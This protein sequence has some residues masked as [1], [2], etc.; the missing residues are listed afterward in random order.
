MSP[1]LGPEPLHSLREFSPST[2]K[3][4]V[5]DGLMFLRDIGVLTLRNTEVK[6]S[7]GELE[8]WIRYPCFVHHERILSTERVETLCWS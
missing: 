6:S 2:V 8:L 5:E 4:P 7:S 3:I 1:K